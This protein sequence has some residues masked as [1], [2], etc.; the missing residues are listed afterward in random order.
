MPETIQITVLMENSAFS[1][2]LVAEHGLSFHIQL[3]RHSV[4]FDT[5]QSDQLLRNARALELDLGQLEAIVL[6]HGHFDHSGGL[7]AV[8]L[9]APRARLHLHPAATGPKFSIK[10]EGIVRTIG[11][12]NEAQKII[13][14]HTGAIWTRESVEVV[15][16]LFATGEIPRLTNFED[17]GGRFFLDPEGRQ[18]DELVDDQALFFDGDEGVVVL[19]GCAH[20]GVVNTMLHVEKITGGKPIH[21][22]LGGMHLLNASEQRLEKT[23][24]A[25][26]ERGIRLLAPGH[27]TGWQATAAFL[28]RFRNQCFPISVGCR[29]VFS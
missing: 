17:V 29:H 8:H 14:A 5:G 12:P 7:P 13:R 18:P 22:V 6:S 1:P 4:L 26:D 19:L 24:S 15:P 20:A 21:A 25:L 16:G 11:M 9:L 27:C 23:I 2:G 10:G 28:S 3:G